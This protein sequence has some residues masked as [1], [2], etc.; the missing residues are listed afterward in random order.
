MRRAGRWIRNLHPGARIRV[1][2]SE[3]GT[4]RWE[5]RHDGE[6]L[7]FETEPQAGLGQRM[8]VAALTLLPIENTHTPS[9]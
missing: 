4:L 5:E 2:M 8:L 3:R 1:G 7:V 6:T 9:S